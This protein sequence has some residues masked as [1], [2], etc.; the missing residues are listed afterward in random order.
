VPTEERWRDAKE[1]N[2]LALPQHREL[3]SFKNLYDCE[4]LFCIHLDIVVPDDPN[5]R[6][7]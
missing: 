6:W 5:E 4:L 1:N 7:R 3:T 2:S